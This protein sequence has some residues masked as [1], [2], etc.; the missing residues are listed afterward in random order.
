MN[1]VNG[2]NGPR[3]FSNPYLAGM[4]LGGSLLAS[5]VLLGA[6]LGAS[7]GIARIGAS[8]SSSIAPVHT[9]ASEY[10]GAWGERPL[11]YYLVFMLGGTFLGGLISALM[12]NRMRLQVERAHLLRAGGCSS[13]S[14]AA[15]L[16]ASPAAWPKVAHQGRHSAAARCSSPAV[17]FS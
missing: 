3:P 9:A 6:G 11:R 8:L 15:C 7:G 2:N 10:F 16:R 4:L 17:S 1:S 13:R 5:F 14:S 12:A